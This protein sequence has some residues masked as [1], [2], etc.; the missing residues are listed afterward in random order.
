MT[1][2]TQS[3]E[4]SDRLAIL[5]LDVHLGR[6]TPVQVLDALRECLEWMR[7]DYE[8]QKEQEIED[9]KNAGVDKDVEILALERQLGKLRN[10]VH[11]LASCPHEEDVKELKDLAKEDDE[12]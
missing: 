9:L 5:D 4:L 6:L 8:S 10:A 1:A 3:A 2:F 12:S 11:C 7:D